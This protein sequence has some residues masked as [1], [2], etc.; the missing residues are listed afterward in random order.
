MSSIDLL[1]KYEKFTEN[2]I[3]NRDDHLDHNLGNLVVDPGN[4]DHEKHAGHIHQK[5]RYPGTGK[6][7]RF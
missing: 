4:S 7:S 6:G 1:M 3:G 5:G 2:I